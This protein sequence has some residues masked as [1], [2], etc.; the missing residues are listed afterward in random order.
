MVCAEHRVQAVQATGTRKVIQLLGFSYSY[1]VGL[2]S[3]SYS[4]TYSYTYY[5]PVNRSGSPQGF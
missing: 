3:Y 4:Y 1:I 5:S 2:Y